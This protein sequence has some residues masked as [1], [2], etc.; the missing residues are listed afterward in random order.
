MLSTRHHRPHAALSRLLL[1]GLWLCA[2]RLP[3]LV[4]GNICTVDPKDSHFASSWKVLLKKSC[5]NHTLTSKG[6]TSLRDAQHVCEGKATCS[7]VHN[8]RTHEPHGATPT[9]SQDYAPRRHNN[10]M[11][12]PSLAVC[13]WVEIH[14]HNTEQRSWM[15]LAL[16]GCKSIRWVA[17]ATSTAC[18][19]Q[20]TMLHRVTRPRNRACA[21]SRRPRSHGR[22]ST[23]WMESGVRNGAAARQAST[24]SCAKTRM[25]APPGLARMRA[26]ARSRTRTQE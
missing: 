25:N 13:I 14:G 10:N 24:G 26:R 5:M 1:A 16:Y 15:V 23:D 21:Q 7:G 17:A 19:M 20:P 18:A 6:Y 4:H 9:G 11:T 3:T 12:M 8:V 22:T 2:C